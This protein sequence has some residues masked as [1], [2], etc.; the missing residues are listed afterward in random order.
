MA[1]TNSNSIDLGGL[2]PIAN[3]QGNEKIPVV[4]A[5][6]NDLGYVTPNQMSQRFNNS[7]SVQ[8]SPAQD[9]FV[10]L[11]DA[12]GNDVKVSLVNFVNALRLF[13]DGVWIGK[14]QHE[15][16]GYYFRCEPW[17]T[18][19]IGITAAD[20]DAIVI[21]HGGYRLGIA[22]DEPSPMNWGSGKIQVN[23]F[24]DDYER[25]N[26]LNGKA[27][28]AKIMANSTYSGD[29]ATKYAVAYCY[30]YSKGHT[31]DV[32]GDST[33]AAHSWWLPTMGD[34]ALIHQHFETINAALTRINNA[35]KQKTTLLQREN[36]WSCVELSATHAWN[37][38]FGDGGRGR[39]PKATFSAR[40]RPV[41]AF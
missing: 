15:T 2:S 37:L 22:L 26:S 23:N 25:L 21:Q 35:G 39:N 31:G 3:I 20:A 24:A 13:Q 28:C 4:S 40:V 11:C 27:L 12:S 9:I 14:Y 7:I 36:Y 30:N 18:T 32:G 10:K 19:N 34:L 29:D 5:T 38:N 8:T 41:T 17:Q 16:W 6:G 33:I 1:T